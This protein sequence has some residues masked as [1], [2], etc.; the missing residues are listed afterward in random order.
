MIES[1]SQLSLNRTPLKPDPGQ[2]ASLHWIVLVLILIL[3][4]LIMM[5][6]LRE[7]REDNRE[8]RIHGAASLIAL[9]ARIQHKEQFP[10]KNTPLML[11]QFGQDFF[12]NAHVEGVELANYR[13]D[14]TAYGATPAFHLID[15]IS[16][17]KYAYDINARLIYSESPHQ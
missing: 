15:L 11:D 14:A 4:F 2:R 8:A 6:A 5:P 16:G 12:A 7:R 3:S 9:E 17:T 13:V 1:S 10:A